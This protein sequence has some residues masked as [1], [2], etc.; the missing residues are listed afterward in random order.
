[1][2]LFPTCCSL[3]WPVKDCSL[4]LNFSVSLFF[5]ASYV[6]GNCFFTLIDCYLI[7]V[8]TSGPDRS[9]C[10]LLDESKIQD[11]GVHWWVVVTFIVISTFYFDFCFLI[12][13]RIWP[14]ERKENIISSCT[15][16]WTYLYFINSDGALG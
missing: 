15:V 5:A 11:S 2:S 9:L 13:C 3:Q 14:K 10:Q 6:G 7:D 12:T 1:M 16:R 8:L 4:F